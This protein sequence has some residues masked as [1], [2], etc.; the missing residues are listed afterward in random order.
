MV[1]VV[2]LLLPAQVLSSIGTAFKVLT[3]TPIPPNL[4][5]Q[6]EA[7]LHSHQ[8]NNESEHGSP[9]FTT[10]A[11]ACSGRGEEEVNQEDETGT[12]MCIVATRACFS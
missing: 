2:A 1:V 5:S 4:C 7:D 11:A 8:C 3:Q 12:S 6:P 10:A 9:R